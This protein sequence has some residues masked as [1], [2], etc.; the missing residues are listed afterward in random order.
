MLTSVN[1][2]CYRSL[3]VNEAKRLCELEQETQR[4]NYL[5]AA[6]LLDNAVLK[7]VLAKK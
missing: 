7:Q 4:L 2:W 5:L 6:A 1:G 3:H